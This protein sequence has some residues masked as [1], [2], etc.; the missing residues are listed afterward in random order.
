[1]STIVV[2]GIITIVLCLILLVAVPLVQSDEELIKKERT[3]TLFVLRLAAITILIVK[4]IES[5]K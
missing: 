3:A 5:V 1:M 2:V 4:L